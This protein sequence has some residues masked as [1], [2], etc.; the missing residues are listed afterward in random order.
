MPSA[1][2]AI[3]VAL[4]DLD[5]VVYRGAT[6]IEGA[7]GAVRRLRQL[8]WRPVFGTNS[9]VKTRTQIS[10]KLM[11]MGIPAEEDEVLT[12]AFVAAMLVRDVG[13]KSAVVIGAEGLRQEIA[14][15]GVA[16]VPEPPC[17]V[18]VVGMDTAFSYGKIQMAMDAIRSGATFVACN[19][20]ASFPGDN[21]R[22]FPGCGPMVAAVETATGHP[23]HHVAGKPNVLMLQLVAARYQVS[24][25]EILIVGDGMDSDIKMAV[26]Y[27]SPSVLVAGGTLEGTTDGAGPT[28]TV[29]S[30]AD[31]PC[32]V[33]G[34]TGF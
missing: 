12:S 13:G 2:S 27:G 5:G 26:A 30:L 8:G 3:K 23:A 25:H 21:G 9:S 33:G 15:I 20:D 6:M 7:D 19:R 1:L 18:V 34:K 22:L 10:D 11:A 17:D 4:I 16:V 14:G 24:P 31:L 32:L 29:E 28:Y